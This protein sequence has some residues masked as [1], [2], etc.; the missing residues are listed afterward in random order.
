MVHVD[1]PSSFW[2]QYRDAV[3]LHKMKTIDKL[4]EEFKA[5]KNKLP[6]LNLAQVKRNHVFLATFDN[7][8]D[9]YRARVIG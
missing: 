3:H 2:V 5:A 4:M 9:L 6:R 7:D 1:S 8:G